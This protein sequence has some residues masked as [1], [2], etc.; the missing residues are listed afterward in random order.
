MQDRENLSNWS[1]PPPDSVS[2][3]T[4]ELF[5]SAPLAHFSQIA[6][7]IAPS[8]ASVRFNL[9]RSRL[10]EKFLT[11]IDKLIADVKALKSI[12]AKFG[13]SE[14]KNLT[15]VTRSMQSPCSNF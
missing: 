6:S 14:F 5:L 1:D 4:G 7:P 12:H 11:T 2:G 13:V 15:G 3:E 10:L 9:T 8:S